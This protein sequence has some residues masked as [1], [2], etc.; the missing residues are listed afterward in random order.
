MPEEKEW[1]E[2]DSKPFD[3][4][5]EAIAANTPPGA[6]FPLAAH[7]DA[8]NTSTCDFHG[9]SSPSDSTYATFE[10]SLVGPRGNSGR[11]IQNQVE[12]HQVG[13]ASVVI[14]EDSRITQ[15][16]WYGCQ[17]RAAAHQRRA[18]SYLLGLS[19]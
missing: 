4:V 3:T 11:T 8:I 10:S 9:T 19:Q 12:Y 6:S 16:H 1:E 7:P 15:H 5:E 14:I 2:I 18:H 17:D 13:G